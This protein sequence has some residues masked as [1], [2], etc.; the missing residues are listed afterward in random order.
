MSEEADLK[1]IL[2]TPVYR[3]SLT[4]Q[5]FARLT[6]T[7]TTNRDYP[8]AFIC[9]DSLDISTI[10]STFPKSG[11]YKFHDYFFKSTDTYNQLMLSLD[12]YRRFID[13]DIMLITQLDSIVLAKIPNS[14]LDNYDYVGAPWGNPFKIFSIKR[15]LFLTRRMIFRP[16]SQEIWIGNGGLSL[17]NINAVIS[18]L[19]SF[20][21]ARKFFKVFELNEG[22]NEDVVLS[23]L[24]KKYQKRI[25]TL[26]ESLDLFVESHASNLSE[27]GAVLGFHALEKFNPG[28]EKEILESEI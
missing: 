25:P 28:L 2:V 13:F 11:I 5:E 24:M 14:V 9:P 17:R 23:F 15:R 19:E 4:S 3:S 8:H 18:V 7:L 21:A 27:V 12:F 22:L 26:S 6:R 20:Y 16:F 1:L 10:A